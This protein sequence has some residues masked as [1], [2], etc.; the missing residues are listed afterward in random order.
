MTLTTGSWTLKV[1]SFLLL[2]SQDARSTMPMHVKD[3][4][5]RG[6][7]TKGWC[8]FEVEFIPWPWPIILP[9]WRLDTRYITDMLTKGS[10]IWSGLPDSSS[11]SRLKWALKLTCGRE[12]VGGVSPIF[13]WLHS[14]NVVQPLWKVLA[15]SSVNFVHQKAWDRYFKSSNVPKLWKA[16]VQCLPNQT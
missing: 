1:T 13:K 15:Q 10:Y 11:V 6:V 9:R 2:S 4:R 3:D 5:D 12:F 7:F 8:T 16:A 14:Q